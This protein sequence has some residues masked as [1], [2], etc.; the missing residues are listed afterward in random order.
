[1][2]TPGQG[3]TFRL[4]ICRSRDFVDNMNKVRSRPQSTDRNASD[5]VTVES[6]DAL[7]H[8]SIEPIILPSGTEKGHIRKIVA[9]ITEGN[10]RPG[11]LLKLRLHKVAQGCLILVKAYEMI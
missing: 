11:S 9:K 2:R 4:I 3:S 5:F 8:I 6:P 7:F 1:M 10:L